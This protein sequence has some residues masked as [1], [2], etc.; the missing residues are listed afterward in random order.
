MV[1]G[2]T[3]TDFYFYKTEVF[4]FFSLSAFDS[5]ILFRS[6]ATFCYQK[7]KAKGCMILSVFPACSLT[8]GT[9]QPCGAQK[10]GLW[11]ELVNQIK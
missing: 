8:V 1:A 2:F 4:F 5:I 11:L 10:W 3:T 7:H 6:A 9:S